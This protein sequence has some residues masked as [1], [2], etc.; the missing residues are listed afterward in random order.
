ML[1]FIPSLTLFV[2]LV[3]AAGDAFGFGE[4][5]GACEADCSKCHQITL[6]E[7][8]E[9]VKDVNPEIEVLNVD[10]GPV[11]GLW[12]LTITA[13]GIK[14]LAYIDF[15]KRHIITGSILAVDTRKNLTSERLYEISKVDFS[16][17]PLEE[18]LVLGSADAEHKVIVFDDP[19]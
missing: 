16:T 8:S 7:A 1:K 18:A 19:D 2:L 15:A 4:I 9:I 10:L 13:R 11:G 6:E 14:S 3:F 5:V 12:E 17:I